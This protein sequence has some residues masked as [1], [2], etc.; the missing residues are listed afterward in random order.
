MAQNAGRLEALRNGSRDGLRYRCR[1]SVTQCLRPA[2]P[3]RFQPAGYSGGDLSRS[4]FT[5]DP[6]KYSEQPCPSAP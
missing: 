2:V 1:R 5:G 6:E 3:Q 4:V